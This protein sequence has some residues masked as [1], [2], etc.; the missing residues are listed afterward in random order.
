MESPYKGSKVEDWESI[1][2]EILKSHPI[3]TDEFVQIVLSSWEKIFNTKIGGELQIGVDVF[4]PPQILG[5]FLH[6]LIAATLEKTHPTIWRRELD[7]NDKDVVCQTSNDYSFEIKTSSQ[8]RIFG[9]RSYGQAENASGKSKSGFYAA[10]LFEK[11]TPKH[12]R[13]AIKRIKFGWID[14]TDWKA[15][16]AATGQNS[17]LDTNAW[18]LKLKDLYTVE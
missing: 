7:K 9:N 16:A 6:L 11:C 17:T 15:Q 5:N 12:P 2:R 8:N 4:P 3:N 14:H 1:T 10:I 18:N 13:P